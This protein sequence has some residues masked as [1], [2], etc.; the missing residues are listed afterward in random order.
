[1]CSKIP[2]GAVQPAWTR[3]TLPARPGRTPRTGTG[4]NT[5]PLRLRCT[6]LF[7]RQAVALLRPYRAGPQ[8]GVCRISWQERPWP[9]RPGA[10]SRDR[11]FH[12]HFTI[13]FRL[14][15]MISSRGRVLHVHA[16]QRLGHLGAGVAQHRQGLGRLC[17]L[18]C[19]GR[20]AH[21]AAPPEKSSPV[22]ALSLAILSFSSRMIRWAI[23]LPTPGAAVRALLVPGDD[24]HGQGLRRG[25]GED[26]QR[27]L[28]P[29]AGDADQQLE[30][31]QLVLAWR[32]RTGRRRPPPRPDRCRASPA[33]PFSAG[34]RVLLVVLQ[35]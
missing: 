30:A 26:G 20:D 9:A 23:F 22:A 31:V 5:A 8:S 32:S 2:A 17:G 34:P 1:M 18:A 10:E 28:G 12:T 7:F 25:G 29:H 14:W 15:R 13:F 35:A 21:S 4:A 6:P 19:K 27:R 24:G 11:I 3:C 33:G 16:L